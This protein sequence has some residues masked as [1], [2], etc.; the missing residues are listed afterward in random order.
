MRY[1]YLILFIIISST[2]YANDN[3]IFQ[4]K[5]T[6][7]NLLIYTNPKKAIEEGVK[8][9]EKS[10]SNPNYQV[11]FLL[12]VANAYAVLKDHDLSFKYA[13]EAEKIAKKNSNPVNQI[14]VLG[15]ISSEY[16]RL[17]LDDKALEY[18]EKAENL[19]K[20]NPLPDSVQY[21]KGNILFFKGI[22]L[23]RKLGN[24]YALQNYLSAITI[25]EE[26]KDNKTLINSL[27]ILYAKVGEIYL[28]SNKT[29]KANQYFEK[30][31][32]YSQSVHSTKMEGTSLYG[33][34]MVLL[35]QNK[36]NE[37]LEF[38]HRALEKSL[39][40]NDVA[41][42]K[43]IYKSLYQTYEKLGELDKKKE[44]Y[45]LYIE[46][47]KKILA[48]EESTLNNLVQNMDKENQKEK[49]NS[50]NWISFLIS[51]LVVLLGFSIFYLRKLVRKRKE[52]KSM[53]VKK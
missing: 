14:R 3:V 10:K 2:S 16:Q 26:N 27:A 12:A 29:E 28:E 18:L 38:M 45:Q 44:Y 11:P 34:G 21:L 53:D 52:L 19:T 22:I 20:S 15:F 5:L 31:L 30:G 25:F 1:F 43:E 17:E 9:S 33:L 50:T 4:K 13:F 6:E 7:I 36:K 46:T 51:F 35:N 42:I 24:E 23:K 40:A 37:A 41:I 39:A 32:V 47:E 49:Q 8:W 48:K